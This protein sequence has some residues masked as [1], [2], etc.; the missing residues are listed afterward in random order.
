MLRKMRRGNGDVKIAL[1]PVAVWAISVLGGPL[2]AVSCR[3]V[4][5][6]G[7]CPIS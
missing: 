2:R 6:P 5:N 4:I 1:R 7:E 3:L